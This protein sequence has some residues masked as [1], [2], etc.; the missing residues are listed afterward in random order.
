[1]TFILSLLSHD[2]ERLLQVI[3]NLTST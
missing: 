3:E 1:M 2:W